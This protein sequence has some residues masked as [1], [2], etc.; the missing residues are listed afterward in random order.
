M[1][2]QPRWPRGTPVAPSGRGP[3]GGRFRSTAGVTL[4][5]SPPVER[6]AAELASRVTRP[7]YRK[8]GLTRAQLQQ[9]HDN[10]PEPR[11]IGPAQTDAAFAQHALL[12]GE[13]ASWYQ[14]LGPDGQTWHR[15]KKARLPYPPGDPDKVYPVELED[16]S[17]LE[18][19]ADD[20]M[21]LRRAPQPWRERQLSGGAVATTLRREYKDG[22]RIIVKRE[23]EQEAEAEYLASRVAD[24]IGA[25]VPA[26]ILVGPGQIW[27]AHAEGI[28]DE[29]DTGGTLADRHGLEELAE[30]WEEVWADSEPSWRLGLLDLLIM[31]GDRH[32]G[33]WMA[34]PPGDDLEIDPDSVVGIDH[35]RAWFSGAVMRPPRP[36]DPAPTW[37]NGWPITRVA[38]LDPDDY[39]RFVSRLDQDEIDQIDR[40]LRELEPEFSRL[41]H[42]A[43]YRYTIAAWEQYKT[44]I[45]AA[46]PMEHARVATARVVAQ[47]VAHAVDSGRPVVVHFSQE[48]AADWAEMSDPP[49]IG[50]HEV[51]DVQVAGNLVMLR[52]ELRDGRIRHWILPADARVNYLGADDG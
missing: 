29:F 39:D 49:S 19:R 46:D 10:P 27:M 51:A 1:A 9:L 14:I 41:G 6:W 16:G 23:T 11:D 37:L 42:D 36:T 18:F 47:R 5:S 15:V 25:P 17:E 2:D 31:N 30:Q 3:G 40:R 50:W 26:V 12:R 28:D 48:D 32:P 20:R 13:E 34:D 44:G 52:L 38:L 45:R 7:G 4:A 33:N 24:A 21:T 22:R 43:W 35:N 8:L